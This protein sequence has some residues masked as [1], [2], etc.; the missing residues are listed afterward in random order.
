[1]AFAYRITPSC[2]QSYP[3]WCGIYK[4]WNQARCH[5]KWKPGDGSGTKFWTDYWL[6][7]HGPLHLVSYAEISE[8]DRAKPVSDYLSESGWNWNLFAELLPSYICQA[9]RSTNIH[10]PPTVP[11]WHWN[12]SSSG[13]F[14]TSSAYE[15]I[16]QT[17]WNIQDPIWEKFWKLPMAQRV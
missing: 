8:Q 15:G 9:I 14:L 4:L 2:C 6:G 1:M 7:D 5:I 12:L 10:P 17:N 3:L 11:S 16:K 13:L